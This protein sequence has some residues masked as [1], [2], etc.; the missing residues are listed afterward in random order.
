LDDEWGE[1]PVAYVIPREGRTIDVDELRRFCQERL[2]RLKVPHQFT[3]VAELPR[4][5]SGKVRKFALTQIAAAA[6]GGR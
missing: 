2:A 6:A 5:D 3:V 4:T 1:V